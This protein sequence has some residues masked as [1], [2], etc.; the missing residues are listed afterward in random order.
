MS[1]FKRIWDP[2]V[3]QHIRNIN[4][5][6]YPSPMAWEDEV[7]YL[8]L[9]DRFS[10]GRENHCL[11]NRGKLVTNGSTPLFVPS[12]EDNAFTDEESKAKWHE[13]GRA[14][15]GGKLRGITSKMGYL[16]RLG[17]TAIWIAPFFKQVKDTYHGYGVQDFLDVDRRIGTRDD[18]V[19]LTRTAHSFGIRVILDAVL[20]HAGDVFRYGGDDSEP[21]WR[22]EDCPVLGFFDENREPVIPFQ[23]V[24]LKQYPNAYP[25]AAIW[26]EELQDPANFMRKGR[27][28]PYEH[29]DQKPEYLE[30]DFYD[31]KKF[32]LGQESTAGFRPTMAMRNMIEIYKFWISFADLD[33]FRIDAAKHIGDG[34]LRFFTNAIHEYAE[35]IGK[36]NFLITAEIAGPHAFHTVHNTGMDACLGIGPLQEA[37]WKVP[38]GLANCMDYFNSFKNARYTNV[39]SHKWLKD[40]VIVTIDDH[41]QVWKPVVSKGRFCSEGVGAQLLSGA[42]ALNLFAQGIP[43]IYYGTEQAL[44]GCSDYGAS[45][46]AADQYIREA[47]FGGEFGPFRS[48]NAHCFNEKSKTYTELAKLTE[49]RKK[50]VALRRGRQYLRPV[51]ECGEVFAYPTI[52]NGD[53]AKSSI[54]AWSRI[55]NNVEIL[56][57]INTSA[58]HTS[59]AWVTVDDQIHAS[60]E[61][62]RCL[63]PVGRRALEVAKRNGKS[64]A[65]LNLPP[66]TAVV[67]R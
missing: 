60:G 10:D 59:S 54:V 52:E 22:D 43:C 45:G 32:N 8:I 6:F 23:K 11:D 51:S 4:A 1:S 67:Y 33:G 46:Y 18:L 44:D 48:R 31:F 9:P 13:A 36:T 37:L 12:D 49:L 27:I 47:M 55:H 56:C 41:D 63:Y 25:D 3:Q 62:M 26:P 7:L 19:E 64:V 30:G 61:E 50:H 38:K 16:H 5:K 14:F 21:D 57:A 28:G 39:H 2:E 40:E 20:N 17:I 58:E 15:V 29:W 66:G 24:D 53:P 65:I 35:R 34:P 42:L